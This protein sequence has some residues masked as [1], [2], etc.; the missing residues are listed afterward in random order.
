MVWIDTVKNQDVI[1]LTDSMSLLRLNGK[2]EA[3]RNY[4]NEGIAMLEK[5]ESFLES[6]AL[7]ITPPSIFQEESARSFVPEN[8][9]DAGLTKEIIVPLAQPQSVE[10]NEMFLKL[11]S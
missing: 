3:P 10:G 6:H 4:K 1:E 2:D 7:K 11:S 5:I 9:L 8:M